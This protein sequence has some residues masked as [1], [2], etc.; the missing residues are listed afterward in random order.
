MAVLVQEMVE[1]DYSGVMFT[2]DPLT[3]AADRLVVEWV[4][5]LGDVL[6]QGTRMPK[7]MLVEKPGGR[8]LEPENAGDPIPET[9]RQRLLDLSHEA[10]RLFG[11]PQDIEWACRDGK[12]WLLQARPITT[13]GS[14]PEA[15]LEIWSNL[16]TVENFPDVAT[17][18]A[19]SLLDVS[20][21]RVAGPFMRMAGVDPATERALGL[22]AG[23]VYFNLDVILR[24]HR[25][26]PGFRQDRLAWL[27]GG[28]QDA[29]LD[30]LDRQPGARPS[31][32]M[33]LRTMSRVARLAVGFV[34][35]ARWRSGHS[36]L[37]Q[38]KAFVDRFVPP[39]VRHLSGD[40][41][42]SRVK[43]LAQAVHGPL[44]I[45]VLFGSGLVFHG[46]FRRACR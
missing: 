1:A 40:E 22:V 4:P 36:C 39:D 6:V 10:E 35:L 7:R 45:P 32:R 19:W 34:W 42:F 20:L 28:H 27:F 37:A 5:G 8:L 33:R 2:A 24:L 41:I 11:S 29:L 15:E 44:P 43:S 17:P 3:G 18:L 23:R 26:L 46:Y 12:V 16:N 25:C 31:L 30:A 14:S 13:R 21:H 38:F 9:S